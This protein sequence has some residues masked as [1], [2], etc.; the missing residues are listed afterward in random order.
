MIEHHFTLRWARLTNICSCSWQSNLD[1]RVV[2]ILKIYFTAKR[3]KTQVRDYSHLR[4][5]SKSSSPTTTNQGLFS[6]SKYLR[7]PCSS[8]L[9]HFRSYHLSPRRWQQPP[10]RLFC[11]HLL[12]IVHDPQA[13]S[14]ALEMDKADPPG[15][16]EHDQDEAPQT[17]AA[18]LGSR[19]S[20]LQRACPGRRWETHC[21]EGGVCG[22][23]LN[24]SAQPLHNFPKSRSP[25]AHF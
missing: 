9:H 7:R 18:R 15:V 21:H 23:V 19:P 5:N 17:P 20:S 11:S 13:Y 22:L 24:L 25:C 2:C 4:I 12:P 8:R 6:P 16:Q 14:K 1:G 3:E 10:Q